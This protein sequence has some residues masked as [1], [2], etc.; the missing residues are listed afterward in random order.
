MQRFIVIAGIIAAVAL[1]IVS[2]AL[3]IVRLDQQA[4]LIQFGRQVA[5]NPFGAQHR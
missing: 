1:V 3:Y 4:I 2:N 5:V